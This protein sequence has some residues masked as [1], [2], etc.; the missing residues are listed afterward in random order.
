M[1][2][3][4]P[5]S[6]YLFITF[7][8]FTLCNQFSFE[9]GISAC[10]T[11]FNIHQKIKWNISLPRISV[12]TQSGSKRRRRCNMHRL[13]DLHT[14][15]YCILVIT[16]PAFLHTSIILD[17]YNFLHKEQTPIYIFC[18]SF[19]TFKTRGPFSIRCTDQLLSIAGHSFFSTIFIIYISTVS[20]TYTIWIFWGYRI[21]FEVTTGHLTKHTGNFLH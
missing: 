16:Y 3:V 19:L 20:Y 18:H 1:I 6:A 9:E 7:M 21:I 2:V 14:C 15:T 4:W 11:K 10:G 12:H 13:G 5:F 17:M 8:M